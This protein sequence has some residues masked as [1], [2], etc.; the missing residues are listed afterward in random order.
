[1][2]SQRQLDLILNI[3][4]EQL[5]DYVEDIAKS[6]F[7][8]IVDNLELFDQLAGDDDDDENPFG[9]EEL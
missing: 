1:M 5:E 9:A 3:V 6:V 8:G 4:R 7:Q 2:M